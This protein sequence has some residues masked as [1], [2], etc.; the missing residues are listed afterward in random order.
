MKNLLKH[1]ATCATISMLFVLVV[2]ALHLGPATSGV[3]LLTAA[4]LP[5]DSVDVAWSNGPFSPPDP[6]DI[7]ALKAGVR[8]G[9][10]SPPDPVD[11]PNARVRR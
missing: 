3:A 2:F 5:P 1:T 8:N 10:F 7:P 9:P 4:A 11:I 6:V